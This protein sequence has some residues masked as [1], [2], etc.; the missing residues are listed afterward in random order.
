M[1]IR[2]ICETYVILLRR[3]FKIIMI[4][5]FKALKALIE[6][7]NNMHDHMGN[8]CREMEITKE[9]KENYRN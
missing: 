9:S 3:E 2:L 5:K 6:Q 8:F 7:K 4:N 1:I